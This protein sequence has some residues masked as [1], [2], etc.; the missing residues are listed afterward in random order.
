MNYLDSGY[1]PITAEESQ[2]I[3]S[4]VGSLYRVVNDCLVINGGLLNALD[5]TAVHVND[6][7]VLL[8]YIPKESFWKDGDNPTYEGDFPVK[9]LTASG[10]IGKVYFRNLVKA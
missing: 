2:R 4:T 5:G 8:E 9:V 7:V 6:L 10:F 3:Q 1:P